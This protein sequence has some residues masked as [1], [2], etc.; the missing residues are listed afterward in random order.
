[1]DLAIQKEVLERVGGGVERLLD[2]AAEIARHVGAGAAVSPPRLTLHLTS[3]RA[4]EGLLVD[5]T[6]DISESA[7][8]IRA[9]PSGSTAPSLTWVRVR[10]IDA[11]TLHDPELLLAELQ[12]PVPPSREALEQRAAELSAEISLGLGS[13]V[14]I[15]LEP[16][17]PS[18]ARMQLRALDR[19]LEALG[20][21]LVDL[22]GEPLGRQALGGVRRI[23]LAT[24]DLL[25]IRLDGETLRATI[26]RSSL[27]WP[28][29]EEL[30]GRLEA[31]F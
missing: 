3:G 12:V 15:A 13:E 27:H 24:G 5:R 26:P 23:E 17:S 6:D 16:L 7:L 11:V 18:A 20:T 1:M 9:L 30:R 22:C 29:R 4:I 21:V 31:V 19:L 2:L 28:E 14:T 10:S 8:V 25:D